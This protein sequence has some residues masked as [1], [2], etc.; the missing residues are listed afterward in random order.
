M[1]TIRYT[2]FGIPVENAQRLNALALEYRQLH[3]LHIYPF[4]LRDNLLFVFVERLKRDDQIR[5]TNEEVQDRVSKMFEGEIPK[6]WHVVAM[7][8]IHS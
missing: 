3:Y 7:I 1:I 6:E 2:D 4:E 5:L 8:G